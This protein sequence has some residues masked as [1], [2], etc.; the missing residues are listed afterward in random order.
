MV[1]SMLV[2][3]V[4]HVLYCFLVAHER[5]DSNPHQL[6][7]VPNNAGLFSHFLQLKLM[8]KQSV[9]LNRQL[10]IIPTF[11]PHYGNASIDMC[12]IFELPAIVS[13]AARSEGMKCVTDYKIIQE[14]QN[15]QEVCYKGSIT[16]GGKGQGREYVLEAVD[17]PIRLQFTPEYKLI[18]SKFQSALTALAGLRYNP[19]LMTV[20]HWRRGDQLQGRCKN[21][22][23]TSV[24]CGNASA[25]IQAVKKNSHHTVVYVATNEPQDSAEMKVLRAQPGW[26][27]FS[28]VVQGSSDPSLKD[29]DSLHILVAEAVLMLRADR[30]LAWGLSE[31]NDVVEYER[32]RMGLS[33]CA[34]ELSEHSSKLNSNTLETWCTKQAL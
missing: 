23:D 6:Y 5:N 33:Y 28:D 32:K 2:L 18:A 24:N 1:T 20:V 16:L 12:S 8:N 10:V 14:L 25:L 30:F 13:C 29:L 4:L 17:F 31:I 7:W 34:A 22:I 26:Y 21:K 27:T 9:E 19:S 11:S 3:V 15:M